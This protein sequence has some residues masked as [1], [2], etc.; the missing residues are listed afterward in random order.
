MKRLLSTIIAIVVIICSFP[1]QTLAVSNSLTKANQVNVDEF[2]LRHGATKNSIDALSQDEKF[3]LYEASE[4]TPDISVETLD[5]FFA[6]IGASNKEI[7]EMD[8]TVKLTIYESLQSVDKESINF[9][10]YTEENAYAEDNS[11]SSQT[12]SRRGLSDWLEFSTTVV[13][14]G[15][16][17]N[18][19]YIYPSFEWVFGGTVLTFDTFSFALHNMHWRVLSDMNLKVY[20]LDGTLRYETAATQVGFS[21]RSYN[22]RSCIS[23]DVY[24]P[25]KG[26]GCL[27]VRPIDTPLDDRIIFN[28]AQVFSNLT[29]ISINLGVFSIGVNGFDRQYGIEDNF[30]V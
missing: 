1:V 15:G 12:V 30:D 18:R 11:L 3:E 27:I 17:L 5:T 2:F 6:S 9:I 13:Y 28:Y 26:T 21:A 24:I 19:Y 23:N 20:Y 14:L 25:Y 10:D 8:Y 29:P 4:E 7:S 22:M 16:N